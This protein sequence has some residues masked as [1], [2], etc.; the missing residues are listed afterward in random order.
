MAYQKHLSES[1][2]DRDASNLLPTET[3]MKEAKRETMRERGGEKQR[4]C[5]GEGEKKGERQD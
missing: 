4:G 2:S 3:G 1:H 5:E